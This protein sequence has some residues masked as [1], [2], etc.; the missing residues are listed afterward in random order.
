[1]TYVTQYK[2]IGAEHSYSFNRPMNLCPKT[3]KP[4]T[5]ELD[6]AAIKNHFP[7]LEWYRPEEPSMWRFGPL[8]ALDMG[9]SLDRQCIVSLGEGNTPILN[10]NDWTAAKKAGVNLWLK[11]EAGKSPTGGAN[12]SGSFKDRGMSMVVSMAKHFGLDKLAIPTQGNAGDSLVLYGQEAHLEVAVIMPEDTPPPIIDSIATIA[13]RKSKVHLDFVKGTIREAGERMKA[14]WLPQGFFNVATFQ[15]P[16][17]RIEGK[18]SLG[19]E[20]AEPNAMNGD[21]WQVP[22]AILYPTGG[23]T[24]ILGM[25]K[26]FDE[27]E[28]LGVIG[29]KRPRI[30]AIQSEQTQPVV[31]GFSEAKWDGVQVAPGHTIAT[32]LNVPGGVGHFRVLDILRKSKGRALAVSEQAIRDQLKLHHQERN[33]WLSPEGAAVMAGFDQLLAQGDIKAK[34]TVVAVNTGAME[35]YF[36]NPEA[37]FLGT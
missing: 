4:V 12:P 37:E 28:Q 30:Y 13:D 14:H 35:K 21:T 26:A 17:W 23:G 11:D 27:L 33:G 20:I 8:M 18:K 19:L 3:G 32:G 36:V 9:S 7:H 16:G 22:D 2:T 24:G 1:M 31:K 34:E 25:W 10:Y 29:S 15:E 5:C 6:L